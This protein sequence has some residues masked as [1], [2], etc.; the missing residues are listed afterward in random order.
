M[1]FPSEAALAEVAQAPVAA[2][3]EPFQNEAPGAT[4]IIIQRE[5]IGSSGVENYA[6]YAAEEYL[7]SLRGTARA[8]EFDKMRRSESQIKMVLS[9]VK[10]PIK[11]AVWEVEPADDTDQAQ[12]HADFI[13]HVLFRDMKRPWRRFLTEALTCVDFGHAIFE[14]THKVVLD[15][16]KWGSYN[17]IA[18]L[19]WRS[20][21][22]IERWNLE[23]NG[24]L[25]SVSQLAHGELARMVDMPAQHLLLF[26]LEQEGD[27]YEGVSML[28]PCYGAWKR[29]ALYLK[30]MGIGNEKYAVPAPILEVP[31]GKENTPELESAIAAL[32]AYL[33]HQHGYLTKP[34]GWNLSWAQ[35]NFDPEKLLRSLESEDKNMVKAFL[36][37][38]L[39]LGM[40]TS[41]SWSLSTDQS[42]FFLSG[43]EFVAD[44]I[45]ETLNQELIPNLIKMKYG[46][47][48]E[49]PRLKTSGISDAVGQEWGILM[50]ALTDAKIIIPDD[51]LEDTVR[52]R[53][54]LPKRSEIGQRQATPPQPFGQ[55]PGAGAADP[56][57]PAKAKGAVKDSELEAEADEEADEAALAEGSAIR[58]AE[59][60]PRKI[61]TT[62][63]KEMRELMQENLRVL[64]RHLIKQMMARARGATAAGR[65]N[66][67]KTVE[68][69]GRAAYKKTL[70]EALTQVA[71]QAL[72]GARLEVPSKQSLQ[73]ADKKL[74]KKTSK[75]VDV[76]AGLLSETQI[77]DLEKSVFFQFTHS[78]DST[79]SMDLVEKDLLEAADHFIEGPSVLAG[80]SNVVSLV[81][82]TSR[83]AFFFED[84]VLEEI[85]NFTFVNA[86]PVSPICEDLSGRIFAKDDPEADRYFPPLHHNCKSFIVPNLVGT[87]KTADP[88]GLK[89]SSAELNKF[90]T[91]SEAER[92]CGKSH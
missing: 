21:R 92:C 47:Q 20:P 60:S 41:G 28:R 39:E 75:V 71:D 38:F 63:S 83:N 56:V 53:L 37:N 42:D 5:E 82:N 44:E 9:S 65:M 24:D 10:N 74:P 33:S 50:K 11:K 59:T 48:E 1:T 6:G 36:A 81:T 15:H 87:K 52:K 61:L 76:Q 29:K 23:K 40:S 43:I 68:A 84:E 12:L 66:V 31:P 91:L 70:A 51:Q 85:E 67:P 13:H 25:R 3:P 88:I 19:G 64:S 57:K 8:D 79:D 35:T 62:G 86:D 17:G 16:P 54:K 7:Y 22:T 72:A 77:A 90:V 30:L 46:P 27:N 18:K 58:F 80:A 14:V 73:F 2:A 78:I 32:K 49:Y 45:T 4:R 89:P 34:T 26:S 69:K 55:A